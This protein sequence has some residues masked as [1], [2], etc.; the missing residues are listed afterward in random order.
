MSI[1]IQ[2]C[3]LLVI[4]FSAVAAFYWWR[5]ARVKTPEYPETLTSSEYKNATAWVLIEQLGSA[6]KTQAKLSARGAFSAA[7]AAGVTGVSAALRLW[8]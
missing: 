4:V 6:M 7:A 2:L 5:S 3:D 8:V 1:V